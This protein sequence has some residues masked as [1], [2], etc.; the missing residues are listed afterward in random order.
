[1]F[2]PIC[3]KANTAEDYKP[4]YLLIFFLIYFWIHMQYIFCVTTTLLVSQIF[5]QY[6]LA[7]CTVT[8]CPCL[9]FCLFVL[10]CFVFPSIS[11]KINEQFG[12]IVFSSRCKCEGYFL[13]SFYISPSY[14]GEEVQA[15]SS[16]LLIP[17]DIRYMPQGVHF[18]LNRQGFNYVN[19]FL[20]RK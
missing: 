5:S 14:S 8:F 18:Q 19:S 6:C 7:S 2:F 20:N 11:W 9:F 16:K 17:A 3:Y 15:S 4:K 12:A 1:M 13:K 10:F